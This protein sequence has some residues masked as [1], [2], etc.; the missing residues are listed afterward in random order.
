MR[1]APLFRHLRPALLGAAI[2]FAAS[3]GGKD[4]A[5]PENPQIAG[6]WKGTALLSAV[7]FEATFT[8]NGSAVGGTGE[9]T[10][11]LGSGPFTVAGHLDG[12]NVTLDLTSTEF[13]VTTYV[14][15][16]SGS[17]RI[18]GHITAEGFG[19]IELTLERD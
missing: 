11:P 13:G 2:A 12:A 8:Q 5:A 9:F 6:H 19:E 16:F 4:A 14:G 10:S 1:R 18:V 7:R 3:C 15:R 17:D